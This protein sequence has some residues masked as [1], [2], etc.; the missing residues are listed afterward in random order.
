[1]HMAIFSIPLKIA[2]S[3]GIPLVVWGENSAF[4]YGDPSEERLGFRLDRSWL[5]KHGVTQG[6]TA[7]DWV[8]DVLSRSELT[9]YFG[10]DPEQLE[11]QAILAVFL[12]YYFAWDV[13]TSRTV[14][15]AHGFA[16]DASGA[17]TG[18]YDYADID[19]DFISI[20][21]YLKWYKFGFTRAF[22][23]LSL[24][25]RHGRLTR[26]EAIRELTRR[27]EQFPR[28]DVEKFCAFVG[29]TGER[30]LEIIEPF[31]NRAIWSRDGGV[32][33][34]RDFLIEDWDWS[35]P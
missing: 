3:F 18:I 8:G 5:A 32:W 20:H 10:P 2:L 15:E 26:D 9:P 28:E 33:R 13:E 21:H 14:A 22:D 29:I 35:Q 34:L 19:D 30:F 24:E 31:R 1:M 11:K 25:I 4:E 23:N 16:S 7:E 27:G 12:G 6:T 17:R